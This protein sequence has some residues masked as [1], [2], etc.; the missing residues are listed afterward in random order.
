MG[1]ER[2]H[3]VFLQSEAFSDLGESPTEA[4]DGGCLVS[5]DRRVRAAL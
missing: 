1:R 4:E 3:G 5:M 2:E